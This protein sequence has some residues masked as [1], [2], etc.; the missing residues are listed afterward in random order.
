MGMRQFER[1]KQV[2]VMS[3]RGKIVAYCDG[4]GIPQLESHEEE[5]GPKQIEFGGEGFR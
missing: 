1:Y 5:S 3:G 4:V 2:E